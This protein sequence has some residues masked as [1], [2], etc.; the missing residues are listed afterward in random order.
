M[1]HYAKIE[2]DIVTQVIVADLET[3]DTLDGEW[4]QT[5]YNTR[6]NKHYDP[7]TLQEDSGA[8]LRGNFASIGHVYDRSHDI[9]YPPQPYEGWIIS[10]STNW[11]WEAPIPK[12]N[13]GNKYYWDTETN[14]WVK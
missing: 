7:D 14:N 13:D 2:N 5:S 4:I 10:E 12:P 8:P 9:F 6:G 3:I 1:A 11:I